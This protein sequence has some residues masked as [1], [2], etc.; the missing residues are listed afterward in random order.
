MGTAT[1]EQFVNIITDIWRNH[2]IY[3]WGGNGELT[4]SLT[5]KRIRAQ[6]QSAH[7]AARVLNH[8]AELYD[9]G[10][11]LSKSRAVDCSGLCIAALRDLQCIKSTEDYRARDLQKMSKAVSLDKLKMGDCVFNKEKD[12][13]H[14]GIYTGYDM[15]IQAFGRD[16]GVVKRK[17]SADKWVIGG[18]LPYIK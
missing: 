16:V 8:I 6:E 10:Y 3:L 11:D 18:R 15:V 7:D 1:A 12:A 4:T 14:M 5:V 2:G 13:T 9:N 17:L